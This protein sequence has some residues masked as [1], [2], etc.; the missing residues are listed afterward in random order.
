MGGAT[1]DVG[2]GVYQNI[3]SGATVTK[4]TS[5]ATVD[6]SFNAASAGA[7]AIAVK[8]LSSSKLGAHVT[9]LASGILFTVATEV[10]KVGGNTVKN[11]AKKVADDAVEANKLIQQDRKNQGF[12]EL[13]FQQIWPNIP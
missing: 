5:D 1:I 4:T 11:W 7:S 3:I 13:P 2:T 10:V 12:T 9:T 6:T 8:T